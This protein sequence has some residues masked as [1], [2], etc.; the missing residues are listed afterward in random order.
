[1][2]KFEIYSDL[3]NIPPMPVSIYYPAFLIG[4]SSRCHLKLNSASK[5]FPC[6]K[7]ELREGKV[8]FETTNNQAFFINGKKVLGL[9][10]IQIGDLIKLENISFKVL[11]VDHSDTGNSL[12][13]ELLYDE[14]YREKEEYES[15][16]SAIEKELIY[17]TDELVTGKKA[18]SNGL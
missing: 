8:F 10:S 16:L 4:N 12:D 7:C 5:N 1:M 13:H 11:E 9:A 3:S 2:I 15:V 18:N 6:L 17:S 14:F